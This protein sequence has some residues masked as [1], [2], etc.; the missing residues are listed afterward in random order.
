MDIVLAIAPRIV[1]DFGYTPAGPALLKGSLAAAGYSSVILDFNAE[2][3]DTYKDNQELLVAIGNFFMNYNLY[4][5]AVFEIVDQLITKW[6]Y[7]IL[8]HSPEWVGLSV[9]S[10][11]S[12][13]A[14]RLLAIR[15][16]TINPDVKIVVG[17]AGIATD[18]SFSETLF[19]EHI[20]DAYIRGEGELSLIQLLNGNLDHP[21]IN[22]IPFQQIDDVDS[23]AYPIYDDYTL[24]DYT[25][26]KGLVALPITGSRGCVRSCTFCDIASMWPKYRYRNGKN[27]A[28]E[29]QYQVE[30]HNVNAFR[31]TDSL[32]NGSLK[33][34]KDMIKEL[35][36]YRMA[37]PVERRF[38]WDS[39]FI[40]RGPGQ[41]KPEMF[42]LMRDSGAGTMLIGV[43]SGSQR[44]RDHMKKGYTQAE[45]DYCME[46]FSRT[47]IKTR[48]LMI[49][50]YPTETQEDFQNTMDMFSNYIHYCKNGTIEEVNLGLT[51]NL[52]PKT[53]LTDNLK[54]YGLVQETKH[55]NNW[56]CKSNP[57]LDYKERLR[58]RIYLQQHVEQLGYKVFEAKNYTKQLFS[59]WNEVLHIKQ[60]AQVIEDFKY[61]RDQGGL[62]ATNKSSTATIKIY[63]N[64]NTDSSIQFS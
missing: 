61:D 11:N 25:N 7:D 56:I 30:K 55:I 32:I 29:M 60:Q 62:V 54:K 63:A 46:Q 48:F 6:A 53:P 35:S 57:D 26:R 43:E 59:S 37:M 8:D 36:Q 44:V 41:M 3:D 13:R 24:A 31:F 22:G 40:V 50:G 33:A 23:L 9:F 52:L 5:Q 39:H 1:D 12:Q 2:L 49:V 42:D 4:N 21:G 16:K 19:K 45:L 51:L 10:Y 64:K 28:K 17:G 38:I 34:F 58:R 14:A 27:I 18:F 15:L 20:I 47:G